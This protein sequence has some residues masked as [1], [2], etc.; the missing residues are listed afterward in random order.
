MLNKI[1]RPQSAP[2]DTKREG[3]RRENEETAECVRL[4]AGKSFKKM[5]VFF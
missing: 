3:D 1:A 2:A 4:K 5:L